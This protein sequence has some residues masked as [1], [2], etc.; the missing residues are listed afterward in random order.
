MRTFPIETALALL[1]FAALLSGT[2]LVLP[3]IH[4]PAPAQFVSIVDFPP[5][6]TLLSP[7]V[8]HVEPAPPAASLKRGAP[9]PLLEDASPALDHFYASLWRTERK[10]PGAITRIVHYGDSPSTAD[11][12]T[13]DVRTILQSHY[14][15]AGHG[16][17]LI[18]KPWAWYQHNGLQLSASG[19]NMSRASFSESHDGLFGLGGVSFLGSGGASST[20]FPPVAS[21]GSG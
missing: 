12:I 2:R 17:V 4:G 3:A 15:D 16:F 20:R 19:W 14:G 10:L 5:D 18:G 21:S 8:R 1:T 6:G 11:L 7:L 13:G 9:S